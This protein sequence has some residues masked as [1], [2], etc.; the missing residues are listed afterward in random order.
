MASLEAVKK[1]TAR[2]QSLSMNTEALKHLATTFIL[3][4]IA[5][6]FTVIF[7]FIMSR[8]LGPEQY[9]VFGTLLAIFQIA[10]VTAGVVSIV[11]IKFI[12]YFKAKSQY[13]KISMLLHASMRNLVIA[14]FVVFVLLTIFSRAIA[15][16]LNIPSAFSIVLLGIFI[17]SYL[18]ITS[19]LSTLNGMQKYSTLGF[20]RIFDAIT[21]LLLG[22]LLVYLFNGGVNG[23]IIAM[24]FGV[25]ATIPFC[26]WSLKNI[27]SIKRTRL[28]KIGLTE[29]IL[30]ATL[31]SSFIGVV[32]NID[33]I[34]VKYFFDS[35]LSGFYAA[36]SLV[37]SIVF[38]ISGALNTIIFPK[39]SERFSNGEDT[40]EF[41]RFG[42]FWTV[43]GCFVVVACFFIF[44][45]TIVKVALGNQYH[46]ESY[47]GVYSMAM[48]FL[49]LSNVLVVYNLGIK[50]WKILYILI[51]GLFLEI[52]LIAL[53]HDSLTQV[54][55]TVFVFNL[56]LFSA[57]AILSR[58]QIEEMLSF[59]K[60]YKKF[61][62]SVQ[63]QLQQKE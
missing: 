9:S 22:I 61:P 17:W 54:I 20:N 60:G 40:S 7:Y 41:L 44:S 63:F 47:L 42:M 5:N 21:T 23:A 19:L 13:D 56:A 1:L 35:T 52:V 16:I 3:S 11:I 33:V 31:A 15:R 48:S 39:V 29:Y 45:A 26:I 43:V 30:L 51:P 55:A 37:G 50:R 38:F 4:T 58:D 6:L 12:T 49:A 10:S 24:I 46:I 8:R 27:V 14:G 25:F 53:F 32:L 36:T 28:G 34:L 59:K 57:L 18:F 2:A 62:S